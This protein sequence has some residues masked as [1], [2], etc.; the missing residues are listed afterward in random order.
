MTIMKTEASKSLKKLVLLLL[1]DEGLDL[2]HRYLESI[3]QGRISQLR[4]GGCP[5]FLIECSESLHLCKYARAR[6]T[7]ATESPINPIPVLQLLQMWPL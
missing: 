4:G 5:E 2:F 3:L 6:W 7:P 1:V